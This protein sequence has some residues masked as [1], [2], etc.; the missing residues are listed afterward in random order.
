MMVRGINPCPPNDETARRA[1]IKLVFTLRRRK[2]M[3][4]DEFK[5]YWR[6]Q[7]APLVKRHAETL[8]IKR[9]VQT[10]ARETD[11]D[12]GVSAPRGSEARFYDGVAELWWDSL[13]DLAAAYASEAG[14]AAGADLLEDEQ[15]FIDM[16]TSPL[17]FGEEDVV[18]G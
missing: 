9:Y 12:E 4:R 8:R 13:E 3:S 7:H 6:E 10:H 1:K 5:R 17:W 16:S 11:F 14:Q 18:I 2:G 15:R